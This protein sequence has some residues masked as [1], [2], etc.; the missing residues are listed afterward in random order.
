MK[1][2]NF[3][4]KKG[5]KYAFNVG[6]GHG[7]SVMQALKIFEKSNNIKVNYAI[8]ERRKGDISKICMQIVLL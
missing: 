1:A 4:I 5:G 3:L 7:V 6:S 8:G 2:I